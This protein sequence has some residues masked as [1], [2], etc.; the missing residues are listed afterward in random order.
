MATR[1]S[2]SPFGDYHGT[3]GTVVLSEWNSIPVMRSRPT[4]RKK[5]GSQKQQQQSK[6]LGLVNMFLITAKDII[7]LGFQKPKLAKMSQ[8]NAAVSY[9]MQNAVFGDPAD[10]QLNLSKV[11]LSCPI[12]QTEP[13]W[14]PGLFLEPGGRIIVRWEQNPFPQK[15]TQLNDKVNIVFYYSNGRRFSF[16]RDSC[17]RSDSSYTYTI[18]YGKP[19]DE[20]YCYMFMVSQDGKRVSETEYLGMVSLVEAR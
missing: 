11:K 7:N 14:N 17:V 3:V 10:P 1:R 5:K 16:H 2:N 12:C 6:I 13:A 4:K 18:P 20:V 15:Y 9:H 19:G 8:Y